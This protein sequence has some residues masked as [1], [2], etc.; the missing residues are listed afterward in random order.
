MGIS[1]RGLIIGV[2]V[3]CIFLFLLF[4]IVLIVKNDGIFCN[5]EWY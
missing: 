4:F 5:I 3:Y 1:R 2:D